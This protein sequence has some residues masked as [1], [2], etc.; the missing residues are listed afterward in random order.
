MNRVVSQSMYFP[1]VG[2]L[3]Q[4]ALSDVFVH[5]DDV[6]HTKGFYNRVQVKT[7]NG[8]RWM[9][10][11]LRDRHQGQKINEVRV[12]DRVNWRRQH[13]EIL[14]LAYS[15]APFCKDMLALVDDVFSRNIETLAEVSRAS[16]LALSD[17]Y[18]L[19]E[20]TCFES[21]LKVSGSGS[22]RIHDLCVA[23]GGKTYR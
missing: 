19:S 16:I 11:P 21:S 13:Y 20:N 4:I 10:V 9:T 22:Q 17:Y 18:G 5:Y 8:I 6:Q 2:L 15:K 23:F 7:I 12:D 14:R 3:E 1:W